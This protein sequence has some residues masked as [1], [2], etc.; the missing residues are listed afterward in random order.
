MKKVFQNLSARIDR[1]SPRR[2]AAVLVVMIA[3][4]TSVTCIG[5][6]A[7]DRA[8][9]AQTEITVN[10]RQGIPALS[11]SYLSR[12]A[13]KTFSMLALRGEFETEEE[14]VTINLTEGII[15]NS[16]AQSADKKSDETT[17]VKETTTTQE[18]TTKVPETTT[19]APETTTKAPETTTKAPETT[20]AADKDIAVDAEVSKDG[21][22]FDELGI[23]QISD[24]DVP[25]DIL[26]DANGIPLNYSR[27]LT[28]KSTAYCMG[29]TTATGTSVHPGVV[30]VDPRIIP[31]GS[32][33]YIVASDGE[34]YGY[35]SA[36]DTG[37]FIYWNNAPIVDLYM[38]TTSACYAWGNKQVTV[39]IF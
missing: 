14:S 11:E 22:T 27:K 9:S 17:T 6:S 12:N 39:Y 28:G 21:Y 30:A 37:G 3:L 5:I 25:D 8:V 31:Y 18:T 29:H 13:D 23:S 36:E 2:C 19:K 34:V 7:S 16:T 35:S 26:F 1:V 20:T 4:L 15:T 32:K 33:M 24:I 38:N 10:S